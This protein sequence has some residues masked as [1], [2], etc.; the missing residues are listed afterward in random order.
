MKRVLIQVNSGSLE[1][2]KPM[3]KTKVVLLGHPVL[4]RDP[5]KGLPTFFFFS[6]F[7]R[8]L[9]WCFS[10]PHRGKGILDL[11]AILQKHAY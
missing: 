3:V 9:F 2:K 8:R 5:L 6:S 10:G 1:L 7:F 11:G 4:W